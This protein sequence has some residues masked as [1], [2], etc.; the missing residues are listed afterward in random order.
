MPPSDDLWD[1]GGLSP[2]ARDDLDREWAVRHDQFFNVSAID[3]KASTDRAC[4]VRYRGFAC[5]AARRCHAAPPRR[6]GLQLKLDAAPQTPPPHSLATG[7]AWRLGRGCTSSRA[8]MQVGTAWR[9]ERP[10]A[11]P[12]CGLN[13]LA[14]PGAARAPP[15]SA[16]HKCSRSEAARHTRR[17]TARSACARHMQPCN[18][19]RMHACRFP[20]GGGSRL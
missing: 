6:R 3:P 15:R 5:S 10:R 16:A 17:V 19:A 13:P 14:G 1:E 11:T 9:R 12:I 7:R 4:A 2:G 8:S 20:G 18:H